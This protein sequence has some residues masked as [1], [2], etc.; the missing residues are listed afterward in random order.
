MQSGRNGGQLKVG[1]TGNKGGGR[2]PDQLRA[3]A[4]ASLEKGLARLEQRLDEPEISTA[5]L[6]RIV[7]ILL[8]YGIGPALGESV[9]ERPE[10]PLDD[11]LAG[12][13]A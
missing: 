1:N 9:V 5:E 10:V 6:I 8:R 12:F 7:E 3:L 4:R 13:T 11:M 2:R